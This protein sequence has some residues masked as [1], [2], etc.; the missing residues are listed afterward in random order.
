LE[1]SISGVGF[2]EAARAYVKLTPSV[3]SVFLIFRILLLLHDRI[4]RKLVSEVEFAKRT[5]AG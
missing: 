5:N 4:L 1:F 2:I 3:F